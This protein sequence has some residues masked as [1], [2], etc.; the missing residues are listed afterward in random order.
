VYYP[1]FGKLVH[2]SA[3]TRAAIAVTDSGAEE[4]GVGEER[5]R[6]L[7]PRLLFCPLVIPRCVRIGG[8][9]HPGA[10]HRSA[11]LPGQLREVFGA[12]RSRICRKLTTDGGLPPT[13]LLEGVEPC[14]PVIVVRPQPHHRA[15]DEQRHDTHGRHQRAHAE[16]HRS[17]WHFPAMKLDWPR[18][19]I[20]T[21]FFDRS[22]PGSHRSRDARSTDPPLAHTFGYAD[23]AAIAVKGRASHRPRALLPFAPALPADQRGA[24]QPEQ[25]DRRW[26]GYRPYLRDLDLADLYQSCAIGHI[27]EHLGVRIRIRPSRSRSFDS[28]D[29]ENSRCVGRGQE[30]HLQ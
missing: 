26:L 28:E 23:T 11:I 8:D 5:G 6:P 14:T 18:T 16:S 21:T 22:Q 12:L 3:W 20:N 10:P 1:N 15:P 30:V 9:G 4:A 25:S 29:P 13:V 17:H 19:P 2:Q 24:G 7:S 27:G